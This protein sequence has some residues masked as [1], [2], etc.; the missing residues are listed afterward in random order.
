MG[1]SSAQLDREIAESYLGMTVTAEAPTIP[2]RRV[3]GVATKVGA[4]AGGHLM[5]EI[6]TK[7]GRLHNVFLEDVVPQVPQA[8]AAYRRRPAHATVKAA[9][10]GR[11]VITEEQAR[12]MPRFE[13]IAHWLA[14]VTRKK[15]NRT[16]A[17]GKRVRRAGNRWQ[18]VSSNGSVE[19]ATPDADR[20]FDYA[21]RGP[22][23]WHIR[24]AEEFRV[25]AH[26]RSA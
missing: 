22:L 7:D 12:A 24:N 15:E 2:R 5:L 26:Q 1:K 8:R 3:T 6:E 16:L 13:F 4:T 23:G 9:S 18:V 21:R 19:Y 20:L 11:N 10:L 25:L 14:V 17:Q